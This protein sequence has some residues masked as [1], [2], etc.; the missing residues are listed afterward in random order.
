ML[1]DFTNRAMRYDPEDY[2]AADLAAE[3]RYRRKQARQNWHYL[4]PERPDAP[5]EDEA[6]DD[7][8]D[9]EGA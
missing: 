6:L 2:E 4:D 1:P 8:E 7:G 9:E 5:P 3:D